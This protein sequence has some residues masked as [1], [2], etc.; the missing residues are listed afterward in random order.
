MSASGAHRSACDAAREVLVAGIDPGGQPASLP[1]TF[2]CDACHAWFERALAH[3]RSLSSLPRAAAARDSV[4]IAAALAELDGRVVAELHAG[5]RQERAGAALTSLQRVSAPR[6]LDA[7]VA[8]ALHSDVPQRRSA[9]SE[10]ATRVALELAS[11]GE[12]RIGRQIASLQ[13]RSAPAELEGRVL[14]VLASNP[15]SDLPIRRWIAIAATLLLVFGVA[16]T[17]QRSSGSRVPRYPFQVVHVESAASLSPF[18]LSLLSASSGGV[19]DL[20][21]GASKEPRR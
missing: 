17:I 4:A 13:H 5:C 19:L 2:H 15:R 3:G 11:G 21:S 20:P 14:R 12:L 18:A 10:L 1:E 8:G 7:W 6:E 9:P 16:S